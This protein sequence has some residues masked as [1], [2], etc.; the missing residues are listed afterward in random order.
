MDLFNYL[1]LEQNSKWMKLQSMKFK[2]NIIY[3]D[4]LYQMTAYAIYE[5][6]QKIFD[7]YKK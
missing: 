3:I 5:N 1:L 7:K 2:Q 4:R 6:R